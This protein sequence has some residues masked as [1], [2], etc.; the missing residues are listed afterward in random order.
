MV[1]ISGALFS[2][3]TLLSILY[4][5]LHLQGAPTLLNVGI[6]G[7]AF[8]SIPLYAIYKYNKNKQK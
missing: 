1:Y 4:K 6:V 2:S 8:V 3:I 7:L 5:L